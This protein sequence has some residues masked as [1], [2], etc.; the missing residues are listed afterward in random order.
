MCE[1]LL[2]YSLDFLK[3]FEKFISI[4]LSSSLIA[5]LLAAVTLSAMGCPLLKYTAIGIKCQN[6]QPKWSII[7]LVEVDILDV[8]FNHLLVVHIANNSV[9]SVLLYIYI[10]IYI[11]LFRKILCLWCHNLI[12]YC[13]F[14]SI[15]KSNSDPLILITFHHRRHGKTE[16]AKMNI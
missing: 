4:K 1:Q 12:L 15:G 7:I 16:S 14:C 2:T 9:N 8:S 3:Y 11:F 5:P 6:M 13:H 10:Y